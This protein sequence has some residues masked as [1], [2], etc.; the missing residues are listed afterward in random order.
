MARILMIT[1]EPNKTYNSVT[2]LFDLKQNGFSQFFARILFGDEEKVRTYFSPTIIDWKHAKESKIPEYEDGRC[3]I[4]KDLISKVK[5]DLI[6]TFGSPA[7]KIFLNTE[8]KMSDIISNNLIS[9]AKIDNI[10]N[11]KI[12][13]TSVNKNTPLA[14]LPHTS[15]QAQS[16][17]MEK[18]IELSELV[19]KIQC[20]TFNICRNY[21]EAE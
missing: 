1:E 9:I 17:W 20:C 2:D 16:V 21:N 10:L 15:G 11:N 14:I 18:S 4:Q 3:H 19:R 5:Y 12:I 7:S 6:V 8:T 13:K